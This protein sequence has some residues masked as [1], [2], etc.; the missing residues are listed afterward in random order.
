MA[1]LTTL[2]N[3]DWA[4]HNY[5]HSDA[6]YIHLVCNRRVLR[7]RNEDG[8]VYPPQFCPHCLK[9]EQDT[10]KEKEEKGNG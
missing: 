9:E 10:V 8:L 7:W 2:V 4:V 3:K 6:T 5:N 1:T